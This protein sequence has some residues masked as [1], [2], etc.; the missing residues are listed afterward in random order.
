MLR[1][2][3]LEQRVDKWVERTSGTASAL[4]R[5]SKK[6]AILRQRECCRRQCGA[7]VQGNDVRLESGRTR[8]RWKIPNNG[9]GDGEKVE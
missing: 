2:S 7:V 9:N 8:D 6:G 5:S 4:C 3:A 1:R